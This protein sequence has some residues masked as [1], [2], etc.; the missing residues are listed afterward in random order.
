MEDRI[1]LLQELIYA[2]KRFEFVDDKVLKISSYYNGNQRVYI[3]L[4]ALCKIMSEKLDNND[5]N[6]I[7][8][9]DYME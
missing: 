9:L 5:I 4:M 7:L 1:E 2:S 3:N 6:K 8:L